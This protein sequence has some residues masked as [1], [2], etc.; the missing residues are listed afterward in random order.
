MGK[1]KVFEKDKKP[2]SPIKKRKL[3]KYPKSDEE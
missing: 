1:K 3:P 2:L